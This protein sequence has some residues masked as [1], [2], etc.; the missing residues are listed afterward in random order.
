MTAGNN[1][2]NFV[3]LPAFAKSL[4]VLRVI[5]ELTH[6]LPWAMARDIVIH[7]SHQLKKKRVGKRHEMH[8]LTFQS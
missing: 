1:D 7:E 8:T 4:Y 6:C 3:L 5:S 2:V